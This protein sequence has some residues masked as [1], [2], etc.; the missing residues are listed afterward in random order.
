MIRNATQ[1]RFIDSH[2]FYL[3]ISLARN[4][5]R[6]TAGEVLEYSA[7]NRVVILEPKFPPLFHTWFLQHA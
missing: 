7:I 1:A 6:E 4:N 5:A 3:F 2:H